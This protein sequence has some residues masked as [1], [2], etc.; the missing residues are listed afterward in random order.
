MNDPQQQQSPRPRKGCLFYGCLTLAVLSLAVLVG[1]GIGLYFLYQKAQAFVE[2][3]A[4]AEPMEL[5]AATY[6]QEDLAQFKERLQA[7]GRGLEQGQPSLPLELKGEDLNMLLASSADLKVL[8][9]GLRL[10]VVGDEVKGIVSLKLGDL[11]A[12]FFKDRYLNGEASFKVSLSEG[13]LTVAPTKVLVND[14]SLPEEYLTAISEHNFAESANQNPEMTQTLEQ[15]Q[16]IEV[17]DGAVSVVPKTT[18]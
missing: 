17:K 9:D 7:F 16:T 10:K 14:K 2:Q 5:P 13:K 12:P 18:E 8:S 1:G 3:Y 4:A 6:T 11:G 15:L